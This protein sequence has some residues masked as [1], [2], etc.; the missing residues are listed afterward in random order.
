M[1]TVYVKPSLQ[2]Q[3]V[4][5]DK[6]IATSPIVSGTEYAGQART[7]DRDKSSWGDLW[8]GDDSEK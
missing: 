5:C 3:N 2:W 1:K 8:D 6:V 7:A 4:A